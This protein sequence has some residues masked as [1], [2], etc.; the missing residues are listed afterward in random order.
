MLN[1]IDLIPEIKRREYYNSVSPFPVYDT[2]VI[3][4]MK[5]LDK[6]AKKNDYNDVPVTY[7]KTCLSLRLKI[8][9]EPKVCY[10]GDCGNTEFGEETI[11]KWEF[12]YE[13]KYGEKF[14]SKDNERI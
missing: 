1:K 13:E 3:K 7:C 14:L 5:K 4:D 2:E 10:C 8:I 12:L 11:T 9:D 6:L